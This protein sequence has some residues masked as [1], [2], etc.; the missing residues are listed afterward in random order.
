VSRGRLLAAVGVGGALGTLLRAAL[1][2]AFPTAEG[3]FPWT[4]LGV[5]VLGATA[6]AWLTVLLLRRRPHDREL[7]LFVGAGVL[8]SFTTF[9]ALALDAVFLGPTAGAGYLVLSVGAGLAGAGVGGA[10]GAAR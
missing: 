8:G 2:L 9:S 4:I 1:H 10:L 7:Q 6:L 5:N 3:S